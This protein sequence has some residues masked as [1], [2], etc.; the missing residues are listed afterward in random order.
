MKNFINVLLEKLKVLFKSTLIYVVILVTAAASFF[1]GMYYQ[2]INTKDKKR[3]IVKISR[4]DVILAV[5]ESNNLLVI[6]K[7]TGDYTVYTDSIGNSIFKLYANNV[8][9]QN[10]PQNNQ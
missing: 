5:D 4:N 6:K 1:I 8:W 2:K 9:N 3:E 7:E 10:N